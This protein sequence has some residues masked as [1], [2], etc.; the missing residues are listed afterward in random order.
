LQQVSLFARHSRKSAEV[1]GP[2][3]IPACH[4][5]LTIGGESAREPL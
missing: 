1:L 5:F 2:E 3:A 4:V